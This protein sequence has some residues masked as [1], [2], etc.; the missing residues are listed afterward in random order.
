MI[1]SSKAARKVGHQKIIH[2]TSRVIMCHSNNQRFLVRVVETFT[3]SILINTNNKLNVQN[4]TKKDYL[5][6]IISF[7]LQ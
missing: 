3:E 7:S 2:W 5:P 6:D 1:I 4:N